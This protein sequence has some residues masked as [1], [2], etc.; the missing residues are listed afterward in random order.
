MLLIAPLGV[1]TGSTL[2]LAGQGNF[3]MEGEGTRGDILI[4]ITVHPSKVFQRNGS[5][6]H[7]DAKVPFHTAMLGGYVKVPTLDGDVELK[8]QPGSQTGETLVM[9]GKGIVRKNRRNTAARGDQY[10]N[11]QIAVPK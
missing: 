2:R 11:V 10:I 8:I 3:P 1:D 7:I 4:Q 6:V 9:K 5:D